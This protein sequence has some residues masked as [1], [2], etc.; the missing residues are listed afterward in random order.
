MGESVRTWLAADADLL[1]AARLLH[2]FNEEF[3]EPTP[4]ADVLAERLRE[5]VADGDTVV[6][7]AG[8]PACAVAVL[9]LR[10]AIWSSDLEAYLAE[11]YVHPA[12]RSHG[13]GRCLMTHVMDVARSRGASRM[14]I[15]VDE[16]DRAARA[17]YESFG[18][19]NIAG[20][21]LMFVYEREL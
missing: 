19:S 18:F 13:I 21:G 8:D 9:R 14:E 10:K 20:D 6:M 15:G 7:L 4:R 16:P 11:L 1:A 12:H 2:D 5:L 17:L 3:Y